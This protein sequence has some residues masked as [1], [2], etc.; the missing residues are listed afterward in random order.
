MNINRIKETSLK[1]LKALFIPK[2][3]Q[4][5]AW[6]NII[7]IGG[8]FL[9]G[10]Y[11]WTKFLS[12]NTL[13]LDF[14]DW[15]SINIPRLT[16]LQNSLK[17]GVFPLHM[18]DTASLH[19]ITDRFFALPD[20]ITTPQIVL[21][22]FFN[23]PTFVFI[24]VLVHYAVGFGGLLWLRQRF[25]L[26]LFTFSFLFFMFTFNGYI[27]AHYS[28]GHFT[29]GAYFLFPIIFIYLLKFLDG[30]Q[31][32]R[33]VTGV[34]F[35]MFYIVLAGGQHHFT[36]ILIFIGVFML[37]CLRRAHWLI[38]AGLFSG[39]LSAVRLLPPVLELKAFNETKVFEIVLGYP[40]LMEVFE[41]MLFLRRPF[42]TKPTYMQF[43]LWYYSKF[44]WEFNF[45]LGIIGVIFLTVFGIFFWLKSSHP[46]YRQLI[47][48]AFV[49]IALSIG[50]TY[51]PL[52]LSGIPL[53]GSE[54][55]SARMIS[56]PIV[57]FMIMAAINFQAWINQRQPT[58]WHQITALALL[59]LFSIDI[60][61]N[62]RIWRLNESA[63]YFGSTPLATNGSAV[64]NHFDPAYTTIL[65]A[66]AT[67]TSITA[68]SLIY[69]SLREKSAKQLDLS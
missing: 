6:L 34:S 25:N 35:T 59:G 65:L 7:W 18:A 10:I 33:W 30:E 19:Y 3:E 63:V 36:W 51:W 11:L 55:V 32:W 13:A 22:L 50:S 68:I 12:A 61:S 57:L 48:P 40:S 64:A 1:L 20:V 2:Q 28:V 60:Y 14:H 16:F 9:T 43:N 44:Y 42:P 37:F 29:W 26:S 66:G 53:F 31:G 56:V 67:L 58:V 4:A 39:L 69:L 52:R 5:F 62:L 24:D 38:A 41:S 49:L 54:R 8:L 15:G 45:Y 23:I 17:L 21:L 46:N 47:I 27:L